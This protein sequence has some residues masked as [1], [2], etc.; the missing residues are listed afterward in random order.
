[1]KTIPRRAVR[2]PA[3]F[4]AHLKSSSSSM[5]IRRYLPL[6]VLLGLAVICGSI[7][8]VRR[9]IIGMQPPPINHNQVVLFGYPYYII[10]TLWLP[11]YDKGFKGPIPT[12][13]GLLQKLKRLELQKNQF[14]GKIPTEMGLWSQL[15]Y[16][17]LA[18]NKL[19]GTIPTQLGL[20]T[21]LTYLDVR[22]N[23]LVGTIPS[24]LC[25]LA[26]LQEI[27]YDNCDS[28]HSSSLDCNCGDKCK[29]WK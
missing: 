4:L 9:I 20:L 10:S 5:N 25:D 11:L 13:I 18:N 16:V 23:E 17:T 6:L 22:N 27:Y 26:S 7:V 21:Q 24:A 15:N 3:R 12:E 14:T 1:M 19:E 8:I 29:C 28:S 2:V